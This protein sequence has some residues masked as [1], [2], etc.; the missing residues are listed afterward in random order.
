M[1]HIA[2]S[3]NPMYKQN[4]MMK[5]SLQCS[6]SLIEIHLLQKML[7]CLQNRATLMMHAS[8]NPRK[9]TCYH[10]HHWLHKPSLD[11]TVQLII[12]IMNG[13][14]FPCTQKARLHNIQ[15][16]SPT[17][18]IVVQFNKQERKIKFNLIEELN[19]GEQTGR[20]SDLTN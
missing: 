8:T 4:T 20:T 7:L 15:Q 19:P 2:D 17:V 11:C 14:L 13:L 9:S 18:L 1:I 12:I 5:K 3:G 10:L 6:C 16:H